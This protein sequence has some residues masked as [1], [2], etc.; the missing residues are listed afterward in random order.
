MADS[1]LFDHRRCAT[2][3]GRHSPKGREQNYCGYDRDYHR[4]DAITAYQLILN[5]FHF[6]VLLP[7]CAFLIDETDFL[8]EYDFQKG[9]L[10]LVV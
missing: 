6:V 4:S 2:A 7:W 1:I 8:S 10:W 9:L 3:R 5:G